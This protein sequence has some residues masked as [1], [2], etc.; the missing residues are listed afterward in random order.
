MLGDHYRKGQSFGGMRIM[1][2]KELHRRDSDIDAYL[3]LTGH[4]GTRK[5]F[6]DIVPPHKTIVYDDF[7]ASLLSHASRPA[8]I[9]SVAEHFWRD[10]LVKGVADFRARVR[11]APSSASAMRWATPSTSR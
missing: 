6:Q 7:A 4:G 8:I 10:L 2:P 1:D 9:G 5:I 3:L 11:S